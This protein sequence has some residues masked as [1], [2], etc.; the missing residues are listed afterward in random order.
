MDP[1]SI[2][3]LVQAGAS[4]L[5]ALKSRKASKE[6]PALNEMLQAISNAKAYGAAASD[7]Q[8]PFFQNLLKVRAEN[9]LS[10]LAAGLR[11]LLV[12]DRRARAMGLT[13]ALVNPERRDESL[14]SAFA[15]GLYRMNEEAKL[16]TSQDLARNAQ[17]YAGLAG[18]YGPAINTQSAYSQ[19]DAERRA[20]LPIVLGDVGRG[21]F[22]LI[23]GAR[24]VPTTSSTV[25]R[26][27]SRGYW[28][29]SNS[30]SMPLNYRR[31]F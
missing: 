25:G 15:R 26:D 29:W 23:K 5:N 4:L 24:T 8:H 22:D 6:V 11:E 30:G 20:G 14:A 21:I 12:Q 17:S 10:D 19:L 28:P 18:A 1:M 7:P 13:G 31:T 2:I 9:N 27:T 3:S 16:A